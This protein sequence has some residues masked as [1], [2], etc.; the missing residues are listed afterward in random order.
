MNPSVSTRNA[1]G[2]LACFFVGTADY[3]DV[4]D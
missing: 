1:L 2:D 3:G 4:L